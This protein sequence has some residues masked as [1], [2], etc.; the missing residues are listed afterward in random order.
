MRKKISPEIVVLIGIAAFVF[1]LS[2]FISVPQTLKSVSD[3]PKAGN[4][5]EL[6][7]ISGWINTEPFTLA[8][9]R[10]KVVLVDFWTYSCIN[11]IRTLP[12][13]KAWHDKYASKGLVIVGVHTPEFEFEKDYNNVVNAVDRYGIKYKVVQDNDYATWRAYKN[14]YWPRKYLIDADGDIRYDHIGEGGYEETEKVIMQLLQEYGKENNTVQ[15]SQDVN[16]GLIRTP[17]IYL[18]YAF[19]RAPLGNTEGFRPGEV[20]EYKPAAASVKNIVYLAGKWQNN[21]DHAKSL[22]QSSLSLIYEAKDVNIV[23]AGKG[24]ARIL[25][26]GSPVAYGRDVVNSAVQI[27]SSRLYNIVSAEYGVHQVDIIADEGIE[28]YTF[29]FG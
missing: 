9:L 26:D 21:A 19:A 23:A 22:S 7:G 8:Q 28:V 5:P 10:G 6:A 12:Y 27:N 3:L 16:Y 25:L 29:T 18:G 14:Q 24:S 15:I 13:L 2:V 20:V 4:A 11:C 1:L 17:E